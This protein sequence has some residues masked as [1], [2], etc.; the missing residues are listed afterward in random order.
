MIAGHETRQFGVVARAAQPRADALH[1]LLAARLVA[2]MTGPLLARRG[3]LAE[4]VGQRGEAYPGVLAQA[5]GG[6]EHHHGM[7]AGV[8]LGMPAFRLRH[9]PQA[10]QLGQDARQRAAGAQH[11][12]EHRGALRA[13]RPDHLLPHPLRHQGID[14][15]TGHHL[16][17]Q[18]HGLVGHAKTQRRQAGG[19]AR[20]PQDAHR[21]LDEGRRDMAQQACLE[22]PPAAV[23]V[24]QMTGL[25]ACHGID[26]QVAPLQVLLQRHLGRGMKDKAVITGRGLAL[27]ARQGM[28]L[29]RLGVQ[30][31]REFLAHR[32]EA[33]RHH[34]LGRGPHHHPVALIHGQAEQRI[35]HRPTDQIGLH[36]R[37]AMALSFCSRISW[38]RSPSQAG[39]SAS[40]LLG[41]RSLPG[42]HTLGTCSDR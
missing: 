3:A 23:G 26:G 6:V 40:M 8:D 41:Q 33:P 27:G 28:F 4:V 36:G 5:R 31:H 35:A 39:T 20:H 25:V 24:D 29:V 42:G 18:G 17:H 1:Q 38:C 10:V 11:L 19:K 34:L 9:P 37:R 12:E 21:I 16:A 30:E 7:H 15:A 13:Q 2:M 14:L 32:A 22:I